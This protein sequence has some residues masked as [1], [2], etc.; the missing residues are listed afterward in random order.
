MR[1]LLA[2]GYLFLTTSD[3]GKTLGF[4]NKGSRFHTTVLMDIW[5]CTF[6][7]SMYEKW[8]DRGYVDLH[9]HETVSWRKCSRNLQHGLASPRDQLNDTE[10]VF[11]AGSRILCKTSW[12]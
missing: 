4:G 5:V 3:L 11:R 6:N 1:K 12:S 8:T 9:L 2:A 7:S 10:G